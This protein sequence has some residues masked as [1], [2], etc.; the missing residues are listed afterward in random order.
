[1]SAAVSAAVEPMQINPFRISEAYSVLLFDY[2]DP[3]L[4][5]LLLLPFA[6][7]GDNLI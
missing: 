1:M 2:S 4:L 3:S 6:K 5:V 7:I